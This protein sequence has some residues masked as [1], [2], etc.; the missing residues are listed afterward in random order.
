MSGWAAP[1]YSAGFVQ[2]TTPRRAGTTAKTVEP[3]PQLLFVQLAG[4]PGGSNHVEAEHADKK[5]TQGY[6]K[7]RIMRNARCDLLQ[8]ITA[9]AVTCRLKRQ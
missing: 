2:P 9:I 6:E 8:S 3:M 7:D 4:E 5:D 1:R